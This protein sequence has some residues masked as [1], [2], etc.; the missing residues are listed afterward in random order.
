[1]DN[2]KHPYKIKN[3]NDNLNKI[4][5]IFINICIFIKADEIVGVDRF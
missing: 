3:Y 1:M 4:R 5:V 2:R